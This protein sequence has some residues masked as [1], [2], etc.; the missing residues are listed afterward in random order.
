MPNY[1]PTLE[2]GKVYHVYNRGVN[3]CPIFFEEANYRFFLVKYAYYLG[4][5]VDTFAYCLLKNHFHF[6]IRVKELPNNDN[7]LHSE[8]LHSSHHFISKCFSNFFNAYTKAINKAQSRTGS[9]F[10]RPFKRL[11]VDDEAYFSRLVAYIHHNPQKHGFVSNYETY[12]Y[13]SYQS[14]LSTKNTHLLREE[15]LGWFGDRQAYIN[16]HNDLYDPNGLED[17]MIE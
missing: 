12:A 5:W 1:T 11:W 15:V 7:S 13:S 3:G 14:H 10:E 9:L 17:L 8:G 16:F 2:T 6:L 4:N